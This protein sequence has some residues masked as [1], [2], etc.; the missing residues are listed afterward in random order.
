MVDELP[1]ELRL[2]VLRLGERDRRSM[3]VLLLEAHDHM[4]TSTDGVHVREF[5]AQR[6]DRIDDRLAARAG[7]VVAPPP[8]PPPRPPR[9]D[10]DDFDRRAFVAMV[11]EFCGL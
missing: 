1:L 10:A 9:R 2:R 5:V 3:T 11:L 8:P 4:C 7:G 6:L